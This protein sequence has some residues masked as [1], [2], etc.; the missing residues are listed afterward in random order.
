MIFRKKRV[1]FCDVA[2]QL[3]PFHLN[4]LTGTVPDRELA[5]NQM[6]PSAVDF[7]A[8]TLALNSDSR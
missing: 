4:S 5:L 8:E 2:I 6:R 7:Q 1:C 3:R